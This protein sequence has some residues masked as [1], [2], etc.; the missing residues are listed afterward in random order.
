M[1]TNLPRLPTELIQHICSMGRIYWKIKLMEV[2]HRE[3]DQE[4]YGYEDPHN[5]NTFFLEEVEVDENRGFG[6]GLTR[7]QFYVYGKNHRLVKGNV[8]MRGSPLHEDGT[9]L[10][11]IDRNDD[12]DIEKVCV[13]VVLSTKRV[14]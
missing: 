14:L 7:G 8:K 9:H 11:D 10:F 13:K 6:F 4:F 2:S 1:S 12:G 3:R 5:I